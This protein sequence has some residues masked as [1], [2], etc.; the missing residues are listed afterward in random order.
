MS[1]ER[2]VTDG[3]PTLIL[4]LTASVDKNVIPLVVP[5]Q[6]PPSPNVYYLVATVL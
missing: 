5:N 2:S 4:E 3:D 6:T 1:N